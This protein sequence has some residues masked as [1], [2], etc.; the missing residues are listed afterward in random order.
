MI[1]RTFTCCTCCY[2]ARFFLLATKE[3]KW[4][5]Q[6]GGIEI[7]RA[8]PLLLKDLLTNKEDKG[9]S[10]RDKCWAASS[11]AEEKGMGEVKRRGGPMKRGRRDW[12]RWWGGW[13]SEFVR[14]LAYQPLYSEVSSF[15]WRALS[16]NSCIISVP[17]SLFSS[18][19]SFFFS[20]L[21]VHKTFPFIAPF[22]S[23]AMAQHFF[24]EFAKLQFLS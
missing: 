6:G 21:I 20:L 22:L 7:K 2:S 16:I 12:T 9:V 5:K 18:P 15:D 13:D 10:G 8:L 14:L 3:H 24:V 19:Q 11:E 1:R 17:H 23:F 4:S